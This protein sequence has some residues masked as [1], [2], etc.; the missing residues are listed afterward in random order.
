M[1]TRVE[2]LFDIYQEVCEEA[3]LKWTLEGWDFFDK[4]LVK[5][6]EGHCKAIG[7]TPSIK[8]FKSSCVKIALEMKEKAQ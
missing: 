7:T 4:V 8:H 5:D 3:G 6:Y 2:I 1:K